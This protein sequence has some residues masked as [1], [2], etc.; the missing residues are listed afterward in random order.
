METSS[1]GQLLQH[2]A[3]C[4]IRP[5]QPVSMV[6]AEEHM[7]DGGAHD[8]QIFPTPRLIVFLCTMSFQTMSTYFGYVVYG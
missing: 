5:R 8:P 1:E 7:N 3:T 4:Y 6:W 2:V